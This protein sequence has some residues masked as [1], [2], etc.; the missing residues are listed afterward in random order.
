M[1]IRLAVGGFLRTGLGTIVSGEVQEQDRR[2]LSGRL[3]KRR[4]Q[5][6]GYS[7]FLAIFYKV[8]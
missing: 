4:H 6:K 2:Q 1:A 3:A 8:R 5:K 7:D